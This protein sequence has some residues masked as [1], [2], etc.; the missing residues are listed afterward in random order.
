MIN[1]LLYI[2][3]KYK[4]EINKGK[5]LKLNSKKKSIETE[6]CELKENKHKVFFDQ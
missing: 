2:Y 1:R 5:Y 6:K 3:N 4:I